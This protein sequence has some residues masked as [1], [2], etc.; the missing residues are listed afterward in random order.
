VT[1]SVCPAIVTVPERDV[2]V[3]AATVK[4]IDPLPLP[5]VP[6]VTVIHGTLLAAVHAHPAAALT[7][8]GVPGPPAAAMV[9]LA[10]SSPKVHVADDVPA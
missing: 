9:W 6:E 2:P 4:V 1:V 3:L 5:V 8:T 10:I 7:V